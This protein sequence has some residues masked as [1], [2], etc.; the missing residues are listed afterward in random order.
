MRILFFTE[1]LRAGGKE[2]R[3]IELL[4]NLKSA[5][6]V[7]IELVL[8]RNIIHYD[9]I[10]SLDI[11][12]HIIERKVIK[13]DPSL[14]FRFFS[15]AKKFK[16]DIIHV[17][18][19]MVAVYAVPTKLLLGVP[20]INNEI[21][22]AWPEKMLG[23]NIVFKVS[24]RIISN[25]LAGLRAYQA[26]MEKS[27]VIYN[28]FDF[29]RLANL[30]NE[31]AVR[32]RF[33]IKTKYV[34]GMVASFLIYKD[35]DTYIHAALK[36]L[37]Q[38]KDI[39]FLCIGDGDDSQYKKIVPDDV[40]ENILFLGR[41]SRVESII[42]VC[43]IGVLTTNV[44]YA[45][46][47]ISN[48][49]MEFMALGKPVIATNCGGSEEL[50]EENESGYLIDAFSEVQLIDK[51]NHLIENETEQKR[52]GQHGLNRIQEKFSMKAMFS[53]FKE[54]YSNVLRKSGKNL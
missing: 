12:I 1:N 35:Y 30:E 40:R 43:D 52:I 15:I 20:L 34:V 16:P 54:E 22:N 44:N 2:R 32:S 31:S 42:N 14:F 7:Q 28:G 29:E 26:P 10:Y 49:V 8:T 50:I 27:N 53:S 37:S 25:S 51:I 38:R 36:I 17:W 45:A 39:S 18:G 3:I 13:K 4:K 5:G 6:D 48:S 47:G 23:K 9:E 11:P 33:N 41:Q 21:V 19:H 46:E 24:D